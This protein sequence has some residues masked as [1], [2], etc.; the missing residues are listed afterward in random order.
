MSRPEFP[1]GM[2]MTPEMI[3]RIRETQEYY[4]QDPDRYEREQEF[5]REQQRQLDEELL[6]Q[7]H[8]EDGN[9]DNDLP[10]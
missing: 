5:Y 4:D 2:I 8:L 9:S 1:T 7:I 10:F 3:S 6:H